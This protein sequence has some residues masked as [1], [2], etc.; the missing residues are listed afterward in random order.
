M[1]HST[2]MESAGLDELGQRHDAGSWLQ[3]QR[4]VPKPAIATG[5]LYVSSR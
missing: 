1:M 2:A 5:V 3:R 4:R